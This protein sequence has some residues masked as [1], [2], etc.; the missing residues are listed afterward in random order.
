MRA[1]GLPAVLVLAASLCVQSP[2]RAGMIG[3]EALA[4]PTQAE[5]ERARVQSFLERAD[6]K[7]RMQAMGLS[8]VLAESRVEAM[9][10]AEIHALA[11][12]IDALPAGGALSQND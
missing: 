1:T 5:Q 7:E 11:D 8:G 4:A 9:T 3:A 6:V 2:A 10:D 12:R